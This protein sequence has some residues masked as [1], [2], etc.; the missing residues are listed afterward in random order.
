[1]SFAAKFA[2]KFRIWPTAK[3]W[4]ELASV[5]A[6]QFLLAVAEH[7]AERRIRFQ[8]PAIELANPDSNRGPFKHRP[9]PRIAL[10]FARRR[11]LPHDV[12][13]GITPQDLA[14]RP[15]DRRIHVRSRETAKNGGS[16]GTLQILRFQ[17][18]KK[19][20]QLFRE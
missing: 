2:M 7:S 9:E 6:C 8:N 13:A 1:M 4:I 15:P 19:T 10:V 20:A 5:R 3:F 12:H 14:R 18:G 16:D 17:A 11:K